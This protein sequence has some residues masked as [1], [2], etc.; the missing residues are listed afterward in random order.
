MIISDS[1]ERA[2]LSLHGLALGDALGGFF[3]FSHGQLSRRITERI[4]P[5]GSWH[6][7][8]D[9]QMALS[10][11]ALLRRTGSIDPDALATSLVEHYERSRGYGRS[12]RAMI[13]RVRNGADWRES[14]RQIFGEQGS[15][16]NGCA[17][18]VP[19]LGAFF[20][21]DLAQVVEQAGRSAIVTHHHPEAVAGTIA[22]ACAAAWVARLADQPIDPADLLDKV[23]AC[24]PESAVRAGILRACEL[25]PET[26]LSEVVAALGNGM[27]ATVQTTV[28]FA[29]WC[30]AH[31]LENYEEAI[32]L[33]LAGQGD[34]DTTCA[35]VGGIVALRTGMGS[36]PAAWRTNCEALPN[37]A[38]KG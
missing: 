15:Y 23:L 29:L 36:L 18:R 20:A 16:G 6:W 30:A 32:W 4:I 3:E 34:C 28:P 38:L 27:D 24:T 22:V 2:L 21:H 9:T 12:V 26:E 25:G 7:T 33:T 19:P 1:L 10:L 13:Q 37:W 11:F 14:A 8:D 31:R 35:I 17:S 5:Q